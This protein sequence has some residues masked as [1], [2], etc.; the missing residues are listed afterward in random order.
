V[1]PYLPY[2]PWR[3]HA[4]IVLTIITLVSLGIVL[5]MA[6]T[7]LI[8]APWQLHAFQATDEGEL[9]AHGLEGF[10]SIVLGLPLS[11]IG[12][13]CGH[14][15]VWLVWPESPRQARPRGRVNNA[16]RPV[17]ASRGDW[18]RAAGRGRVT[19]YAVLL[20]SL[21]FGYSAIIMQVFYIVWRLFI[22]TETI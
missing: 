17:R 9:M 20:V 8:W 1:G 5:L 4:R 2:K 13:V 6:M 22:A 12:V 16:T 7:G 3:D 14:F 11:V 21:A 15:A 10:V 19:T 18:A